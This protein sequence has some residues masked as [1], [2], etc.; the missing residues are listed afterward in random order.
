MA[1]RLHRC[2]EDG[3]ADDVE[4]EDDEMSFMH[5][6]TYSRHSRKKE[7]VPGNSN[8]GHVKANEKMLSIL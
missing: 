4:D 8:R 7:V 3:D 2:S 6:L 1:L 5:K